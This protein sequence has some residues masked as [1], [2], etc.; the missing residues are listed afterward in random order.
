MEP[1][2]KQNLSIF[3]LLAAKTILPQCNDVTCMCNAIIHMHVYVSQEYL[4]A[5]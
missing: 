3:L 1:I 4:E 5:T 2:E